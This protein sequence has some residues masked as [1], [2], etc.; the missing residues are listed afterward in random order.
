MTATSRQ[1][2]TT[3]GTCGEGV[4]WQA[5]RYGYGDPRRRECHIADTGCSSHP[6]PYSVGA[7]G[8]VVGDAAVVPRPL[9]RLPDPGDHGE[10]PPAARAAS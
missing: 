9:R 4:S 5:R 1:A 10:K 2:D 3:V 6:R 7:C 8:G